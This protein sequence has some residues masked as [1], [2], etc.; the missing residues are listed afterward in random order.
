MLAG[1]GF[2]RNVP[3]FAR[4]DH[5]MYPRGCLARFDVHPDGAVTEATA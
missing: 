4:P 1:E 2:G 5:G 3:L